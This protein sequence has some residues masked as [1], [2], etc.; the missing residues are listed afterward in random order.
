MGIVKMVMVVVS[1]VV[2]TGVAASSA[3]PRAVEVEA[4]EGEHCAEVI[5]ASH[6]IS[7]GCEL[8]VTAGQV[9]LTGH[10]G[11]GEVALQVCNHEF[12]VHVGED[13]SGAIGGQVL[14]GPICRTP[15]CAEVSGV[16]PWAV[17]LSESS[18]SDESIRMAFCFA[19]SQIGLIACTI[20]AAVNG[21]P[22]GYGIEAQGAPCT[23]GGATMH[24]EI[25]GHWTLEAQDVVVHH[26]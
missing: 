19:G 8:H 23:P 4:A 12:T 20:D 1:V 25:S 24:Y 10:T 21:G 5:L 18:P 11:A 14:T 9:A 6:D 2:A 16:D 22:G 17:Q 7:G 3:S 13:G 15:P 26:P